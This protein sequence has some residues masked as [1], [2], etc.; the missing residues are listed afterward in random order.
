M[1][2][3]AGNDEANGVGE[4][5]TA[6]GGA[7]QSG[8]IVGK[9]KGRALPPDYVALRALMPFGKS[10]GGCRATGANLRGS[11]HLL[12]NRTEAEVADAEHRLQALLADPERRQGVYPLPVL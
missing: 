2:S 6:V 5:I 3:A 7:A 9:L 1:A 10:H 4:D 11:G 8:A 12:H